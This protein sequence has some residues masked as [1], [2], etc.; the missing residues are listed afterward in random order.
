VVK[1][2]FGLAGLIC[3]V[4]LLAGCFDAYAFK[5]HEP[6][7]PAKA[8]SLPLTPL[9]IESGG[10]MHHFQVEVAETD[11]QQH[12]GLMHRAHLDADR[13]ML[14]P[15]TRPAQVRFWMRNTFI[16]LDMLF[17]RGDAS[18]AY[19][20]EDVQPHD[21]SGVGPPFSVVAVLELPNGT[22]S[23]FRIKVGDIIHHALFGNL[24]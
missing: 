9:V 7:N 12:T 18:V 1:R 22:V 5:P 10:Q 19:I 13:G 16:P 3:I 6:L 14:F 4:V 21:E 8:Q 20:A 17:I 2:R 15:Y 23:H 24:P 11:E